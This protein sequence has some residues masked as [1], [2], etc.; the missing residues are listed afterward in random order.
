MNISID[1]VNTA[2]IKCLLYIVSMKSFLNHCC[3]FNLIQVV[4]ILNFPLGQ[5]SEGQK[6]GKWNWKPCHWLQ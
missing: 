1:T 4:F 5:N 3:E 6:K 2:Q